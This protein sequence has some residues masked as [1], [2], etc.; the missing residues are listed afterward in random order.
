MLEMN[1]AEL[2]AMSDYI[3][4]EAKK[5]MDQVAQIQAEVGVLGTHWTG[6]A[7]NTFQTSFNGNYAR[8]EELYASL[9]Q[10]VRSISAAAEQGAQT[11]KAIMD[12]MNS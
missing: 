9:E 1:T 10:I 4:A 11:E 2:Q 8:C 12:I 5:Y 6:E 3:L 7:F